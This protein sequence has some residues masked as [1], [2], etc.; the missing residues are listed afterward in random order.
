MSISVETSTTGGYSSS[1]KYFYRIRFEVTGNGNRNIQLN[2]EFTAN[3]TST[4][5]LKIESIYREYNVTNILNTS[6]ASIINSSTSIT[7]TSGVAT[8]D[9]KAL[10]TTN[11]LQL[12]SVVPDI[13]YIVL[14]NQSS[15]NNTPTIT[16]K[17]QDTTSTSFTDINGIVV[18][19][20]ST[21]DIN[22]KSPV[23]VNLNIEISAN[24]T[25]EIFGGDSFNTNNLDNIIIAKKELPAASLNGFIQISNTSNEI[26]GRIQGSFSTTDLRNNLQRVL[27]SPFDCSNI[28]QATGAP[29][30]F[31]SISNISLKNN[32]SNFGHVALKVYLYYLFSNSEQVG[33]ITNPDSFVR[34]LLST[35][36]SN[37]KYNTDASSSTTI[38]NLGTAPSSTASGYVSA[39]ITATA[40]N[41]LL[42]DRIIQ[43]IAQKTNVSTSD[44]PGINVSNTTSV[45][46]IIKQIL[47]QDNT[48]VPNSTSTATWS[49]NLFSKYDI[50]YINIK[51]AK[52]IITLSGTSSTNATSIINNYTNKVIEN[53][54]ALQITLS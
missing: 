45:A 24:G 38:G 54:Y 7:I 9:P 39:T 2:Y 28:D 27:L 47:G 52:P 1:G 44:Y 48:R 50:I 22:F 10:G 17:L 49:N 8:L 13:Y 43:K 26:E 18:D 34:N 21:T 32:I 4:D 33:G 36:D 5:T 30:P 15:D 12:S 6:D 29:D 51:L 23:K 42:V 35:S 3:S 41:G 19:S 14:S 46:P 31:V 53:N 16:I 20:K 25:L 11:V 37:M 40:T